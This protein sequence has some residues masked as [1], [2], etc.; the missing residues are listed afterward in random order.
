M[1]IRF[2]NE[3]DISGLIEFLKL[4]DSEFIPPLSKKEGI[5]NL[6]KECLKE[7][8]ILV[9]EENEKL[10]GSLGYKEDEKEKIAWIK[11]LAIHPNY[12]KR[13]FG[14]KLTEKIIKFAKDRGI[15]KVYTT[16]PSNNIPSIRIKEKLN[17]KMWKRV[18]N[19]R[20]RGVDGL[21]F[22]K[23]L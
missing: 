20:A 13:G 8:W 3:K 19:E 21:Y 1:K 5:E 17:F 12:R 23:E 16:A 6:I 15:N 18:K 2:A 22:F 11:W 9:L 4:V 10:I 14:T 7:G